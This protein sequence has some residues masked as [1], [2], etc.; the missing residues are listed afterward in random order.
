VTVDVFS[1]GFGGALATIIQARLMDVAGAAQ[2]LA[3][4][5]NHVAFNAANALGPFLAGLALAAGWGLGA[6]G[7]VGA[8]LCVSGLVMWVLTYW[9]DRRRG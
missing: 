3:A 6:T 4:A 5:L 8:L 9:Y 7:E 2:N 1:I